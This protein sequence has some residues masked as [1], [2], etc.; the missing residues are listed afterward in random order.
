[1][2]FH[3][4]IKEE[5]IELT[6]GNDEVKICMVC[7]AIPGVK[8]YG[9]IAC[10]SCKIFF[11]RA[12][13]VGAL[14]RCQNEKLCLAFDFRVQ[15]GKPRCAACRYEKC[16]NA[17]MLPTM[18]ARRSG[19]KLREQRAHIGL[20][21][22]GKSSVQQVEVCPQSAVAS[23]SI[24]AEH[25]IAARLHAQPHHLIDQADSFTII[26]ALVSLQQ[27]LLNDDPNKLLNYDFTYCLDV[28]IS[29]ALQNPAIVCPRVPIQ[30]D[31]ATAPPI[32]KE[33]M[34][35]LAGRLYARGFVY[36]LDWVRAIPEFWEIDV[37][38]RVG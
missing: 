13:T 19:C 8:V 22:R 36:V 32:P 17:G 12:C 23:Q 38:D 18:T 33:H 20:K 16:L 4:E 31:P 30:W 6:T 28:S 7:G 9:A 1:M 14:P 35:T 21:G 29:D 2:A 10:H 11:L 34:P 3:Q 5:I 15:F 27:V 37:E 24:T 25:Q 26:K